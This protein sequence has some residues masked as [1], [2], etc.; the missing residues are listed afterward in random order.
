MTDSGP[1]IAEAELEAIFEEFY[2]VAERRQVAGTGL[3]LAIARRLVERHGGRIWAESE[4][5]HGA[6]FH[7]LLPETAV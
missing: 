1:G 7:L 3:G 5:G 2:R 6:V 4:L